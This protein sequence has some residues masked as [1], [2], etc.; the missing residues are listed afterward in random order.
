MSETKNTEQ[1][2][3]T[4]L[5]VY[6]DAVGRTIVGEKTETT[7]DTVKLKNPVI[8]NVI[9]AE[10]GRMTVQL[11]P[12]FFREFLA[13]K[14]EDITFTYNKQALSESSINAL[15]FRLIAQYNQLFNKNN[16]YV[17]ATNESNPSEPEK[18]SVVNLFDE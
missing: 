9:P 10:G 12:V 16:V 13:D 14:T 15:D 2:P 11:Y 1:T 5:S 17:P 4:V 8:L 18:A 6:L 3:H 7:K